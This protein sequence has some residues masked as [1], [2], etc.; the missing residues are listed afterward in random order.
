MTD[1]RGLTRRD[2]LRLG[3]AA[4]PLSLASACGWDGGPGL[5]PKVK[6]VSRLEDWRGEKVF[7]S[8]SRLAREYPLSARTP[9]P[10]FT[11]YS[12]TYNETGS[13]PAVPDLQSWALTVGGLVRKSVRLSR[14]DLEALPRLTYTVKHH[15]VEGWTAIGTWTGVPLSAIASMV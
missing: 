1:P 9:D 4:G 3:M 12:I 15:C 11:A 6:A 8:T 5:A 10:Q 2:L 14:A 7:F 13:Y